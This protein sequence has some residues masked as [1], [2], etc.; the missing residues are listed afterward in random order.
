M[1]RSN[2]SVLLKG[3]HGAIGKQ[4]V[5]KQYGKRT[6]VTKYPD[7]SPI[8][9]SELQQGKR[10]LFKEAVAY[11]KNI[12]R[13]PDQQALYAAKVKRGETVYHFALKEYLA[14]GKG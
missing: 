11:A 12:L 4:I 1:A 8:R 14:K 5:V 10:S 9:P 13:D 2:T 7:M 6:V 3:L